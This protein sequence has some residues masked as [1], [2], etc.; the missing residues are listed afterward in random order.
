MANWPSLPSDLPAATLRSK[1][2]AKQKQRPG[3]ELDEPDNTNYN[4][5]LAVADQSGN[6][7][8][9]LDGSF[10]LGF[11]SLGLTCSVSAL[12][13]DRDDKFFVHPEVADASL[14]DKSCVGLCPISVRIPWLSMS[15]P[16]DVAKVSTAVK[17]LT[18]FALCVIKEMKTAWYGSE[19]H[20]GARE[21]G[22]KWVAQLETRQKDQFGSE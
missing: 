20:S 8:T 19:A 11:V 7:W 16:R 1:K 9:Y 22:A 17:D 4:T 2:V 5:V 3:E 15:I 14:G 13:T 21:W 10:P 18:W 6:M 12:D